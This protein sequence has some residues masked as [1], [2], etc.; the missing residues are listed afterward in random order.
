[1]KCREMFAS[2]GALPLASLASREA[3]PKELPSYWT[4]RLADV[5][6][7]V[8]Q[9]EKGKVRVLARSAGR[10][11]VH[12][13]TYGEAK[14]SI[15]RLG[16]RVQR[17]YAEAGLPHGTGGPVPREVGEHFPP[18]WFNLCSALHHACE[19]SAFVYES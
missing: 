12:L 3:G 15:R 14:E 1:M 19:A 8:G 7:A 13:V 2:L 16:D 5:D 4:S 17:R 18:P 6:Q 10:R 9:V 11:P